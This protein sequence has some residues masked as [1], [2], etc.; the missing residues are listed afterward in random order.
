MRCR[1]CG[2]SFGKL[3]YYQDHIKFVHPEGQGRLTKSEA[4]EEEDEEDIDSPSDPAILRRPEKRN[5]EDVPIHDIKKSKLTVLTNTPSIL[6]DSQDNLGKEESPKAEEK[7]EAESD[8]KPSDASHPGLGQLVEMPDGTFVI[9]NG[10]TD[11]TAGSEEEG[12]GESQV[13]L[14]VAMGVGF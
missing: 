1:E 7:F 14:N 8:T 12:P 3:K 6:V 9:V 2:H 11:E 4:A 10:D 5:L 13:S